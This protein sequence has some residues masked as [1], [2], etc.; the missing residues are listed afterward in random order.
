[1]LLFDTN[2][3][4]VPHHVEMVQAAVGNPILADMVYS[5]NG[6]QWSFVDKKGNPIICEWGDAVTLEQVRQVF[7]ETWLDR[8]LYKMWLDA[9]DAASAEK[10]LNENWNQRMEYYRPKLTKQPPEAFFAV[11]KKNS[12]VVGFVIFDVVKPGEAFVNPL[13]I[14]PS[15]Q[16]VGLGKELLFS[17][18]KQKPDLKRIFL[19][20]SCDHADAIAF[21]K[22]LGFKEFDHQE[23]HGKQVVFFEWSQ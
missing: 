11:A 14:H 10:K 1:M 8:G 2:K 21:Y 20:T 23:Y 13:M 16:S 9:T 19:A 15:M 5:T 12:A 17:V 4:P 22:H 3:A 6:S 7:I 18:L